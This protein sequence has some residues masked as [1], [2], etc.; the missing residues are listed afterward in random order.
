MSAYKVLIVDDSLIAVKKLTL[1]LEG[2]GHKVVGTAGTGAEAVEAYRAHNPDLVTMDIT[3]PDMDG[4]EATAKIIA[5][6]PA[7]HIIM[8]TS[9][10]QER[11]VIDSLDAGAKGYV[12]KPVRTEK[13]SDMIDKVMLRST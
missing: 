4:V 10:G 8:V 5:E 2:L 7:A 6:F 13:L 1:M 3:M 9:H 12:L 11:M